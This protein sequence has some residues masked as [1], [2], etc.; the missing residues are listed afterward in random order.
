MAALHTGEIATGAILLEDEIA[1][2]MWAGFE[3]GHGDSPFITCASA[4]SWRIL[5]ARCRTS[6]IR[7]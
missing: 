6:A 5:S 1:T 7:Q 4:L 3:Q 2:A